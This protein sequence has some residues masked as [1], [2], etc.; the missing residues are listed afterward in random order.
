MSKAAE[1]MKNVGQNVK[2]NV[3]NA[4]DKIKKKKPKKLINIIFS[5]RT[6]IILLLLLQ[7]V[8]IFVTFQTLYNQYPY[9]H[10]AFSTV[11]AVLAVYILNTNENPAYKLAWIM[12][13]LL[14]SCM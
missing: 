2:T 9:L 10:I 3:I 7:F 14:Q 5:Q 4:K 13:I 12:P 8:L 6:T 1:S 11:A